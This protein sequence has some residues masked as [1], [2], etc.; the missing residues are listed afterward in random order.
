M[1]RKTGILIYFQ[2]TNTLDFVNG[3]REKMED[4]EYK[5][6][7]YFDGISPTLIAKT[8]YFRSEVRKQEERSLEK[9][10]Y[11]RTQPIDKAI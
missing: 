5:S 9:L 4:I 1:L 8:I 6:K 7:K 10:G 3:L 2:C 11:W